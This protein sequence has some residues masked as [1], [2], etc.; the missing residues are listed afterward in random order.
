MINKSAGAGA[1]DLIARDKIWNA[2]QA[3]G[4]LTVG[5]PGA[6]RKRMMRV[7]AIRRTPPMKEEIPMLGERVQ[8]GSQGSNLGDRS[9]LSRENVMFFVLGEVK[10]D[11]CR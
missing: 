1:P 5:L 9:T 8:C 3:T 2:S 10:S 4:N 6:M 11:G 7:K